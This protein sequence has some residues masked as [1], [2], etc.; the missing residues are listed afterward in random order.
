MKVSSKGKES[1]DEQTGKT[2][3]NRPMTLRQLQGAFYILILGNIAAFIAAG[4]ELFTYKLTK[5]LLSQ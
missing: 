5:M 3:N 2:D 4:T 1:P